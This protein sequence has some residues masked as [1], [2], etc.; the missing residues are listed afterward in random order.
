MTTILVPEL[1]RSSLEWMS[2][3]RLMLQT[4]SSSVQEMMPLS[5]EEFMMW[6]QV[7]LLKLE[8]WKAS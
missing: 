5:L 8:S 2:M 4:P 6:L 7:H 1:L 3:L